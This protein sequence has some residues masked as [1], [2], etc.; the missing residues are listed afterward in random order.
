MTHSKYP[1]IK[2]KASKYHACKAG[3]YDSRKE[4]RRA[5]QLKIMQ[6]QGLISGLRE[7]VTFELIPAQRDADGKV[8]ERSCSYRADFVYKDSD[9]RTVVE[10]AK[11]YRTP[12][13]RI[14]RKLMLKV[15]GVR[16]SEV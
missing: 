13:Y 8:L 6:Q 7:Q 14:K 1:W 12:V 2:P 5:R 9:G 4:Y 16:I 15:H 11:G 3:G 10:D